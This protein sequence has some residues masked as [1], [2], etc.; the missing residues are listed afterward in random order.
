MIIDH[1][2]PPVPIAVYNVMFAN[3]GLFDQR[4]CD[5]YHTIMPAGGRLSLRETT[6]VKRRWEPKSEPS[7]DDDDIAG[8]DP[9][10]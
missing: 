7:S 5:M 2:S 6:A 1:D 9:Y 3:A 10:L 8:T 4:S